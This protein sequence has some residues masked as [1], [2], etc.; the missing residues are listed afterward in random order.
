MP[1]HLE[2]DIPFQRPP[3]APAHRPAFYTACHPTSLHTIRPA[4]KSVIQAP[5][6]HAVYSN[7]I[8]LARW[9]HIQQIAA[10]RLATRTRTC[11]C[12][13]THTLH[14]FKNKAPPPTVPQARSTRSAPATQSYSTAVAFRSPHHLKARYSSLHPTQTAATLALGICTPG[15][16]TVLGSRACLCVQLA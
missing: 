3:L 2:N 7:R 12:T 1:A 4:A 10:T 14:V 13:H 15:P 11:T 9:Q 16:P 6:A 8:Y 5:R